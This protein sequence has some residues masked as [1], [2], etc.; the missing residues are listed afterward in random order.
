M[1]VAKMPFLQQSF[2]NIHLYLQEQQNTYRYSEES[3]ELD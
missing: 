3:Q 2:S 1:N